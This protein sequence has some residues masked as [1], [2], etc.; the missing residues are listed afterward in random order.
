MEERPSRFNFQEIA[1]SLASVV[2]QKNV[3]VSRPLRFDDLLITDKQSKVRRFEPNALQSVFNDAIFESTYPIRD[4]RINP[5]RMASQR[6]LV[7]KARQMGFSTDIL[8][9]LFLDTYSN[10]NRNTVIIAHDKDSTVN[11]FSRVQYMYDNLP[12][13]RTRPTKFASKYEYLWDDINSRFQ[14]GTAGTEEF[15][16]SRTIHN[17]LLSEVPSWPDSAKD[18]FTSLLQAVPYEGNIFIESTAKGMDALFYPIWTDAEAGESVFVPHFYS[19]KDFPEYRLPEEFWPRSLP[20]NKQDMTKLDE[21]ELRIVEAYHLDVEQLAWR[22]MKLGEPGMDRRKFRQEYPLSSKEAFIASGDSYFDDDLLNDLNMLIESHPNYYGLTRSLSK[23]IPHWTTL[24][25]RYKDFGTFDLWELPKRDCA[26]L[27]TVDP[28]EGLTKDGKHDYASIDIFNLSTWEQVGH[29]HLTIPAPTLGLLLVELG[30][31]FNT[32]TLIPERNNH[33]H[34]TIATIE[35]ETEYPFGVEGLWRDKDEKFGWLALER[36]KA[37]GDERLK[38]YLTDGSMKVNCKETLQE[39]M[40]YVEKP[41]GKREAR[42]GANDDRVTTLRIAACVLSDLSERV[43]E[44]ESLL[45]GTPKFYS[46]S[47]IKQ[48]KPEIYSTNG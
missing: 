4:W 13:E 28:I 10:P 44:S 33:G 35:R 26:Y 2:G 16:R 29:L 9:L 25:H 11:L 42:S 43:P 37:I 6:R 20:P 22:R 30:Y 36:T 21:E 12:P 17:C 40:S 27:V 41:G 14:V 32:A 48:F 45:G 7:L 31:W 19:W 3:E 8:A 24:L 47:K 46:G 38:R 23:H 5:T 34:A 39:L 18:T 15:G 1:D